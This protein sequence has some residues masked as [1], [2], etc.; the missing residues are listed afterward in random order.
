M[1]IS[2]LLQP[3]RLGPLTP[4]NRL[5]RAGTSETMATQ[6]G[7]VTDGLLR[8]YRALAAGGVGAIFTGHLFVHPRA[9]YAPRQT[10]IHHDGLL[11]GLRR[12]TDT[13]HASGGLI[14]AQL[15]HAGSQSRMP[16]VVPLTPSAVPNALTGRPVTAATDVEIA[17][18]IDAFVA[19]ARRA[20]AAGFDG[21]HIHAANG[22]LISQFLSP[23]TNQRDDQWGGD[24]ERRA[25]FLLEVVRLVRDVVPAN[26]ALAVKLGMVDGR[27]ERSGALGL[28]ET[29]PLAARLTDAG[30]DAIEVAC[31]VMDRAS[32]SAREYVAV[33]RR[34][35]AEDLL[36]HRLLATPVAEAYWLPWVRAL[37]RDVDT[38]VVAVGGMRHIQT[39]ANAIALGDAEFVAMARPFI[40]EPDL[41]AQITAGRTGRVG[42]TSCNL[43]LRH[44]G[45]HPLRCWRTPRQRLLQHAAYEVTGTL[46]RGLGK[47]A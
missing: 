3:G 28:S 7:A 42:C 24:S 29:V 40:R 16:T 19:G 30:V 11:A 1:T 8:L 12:L 38:T 33:N 34:R 14:F 4:A 47:P 39:M 15:G 32:D 10:G 22:Y 9:Q 44:E 27:A 6:D 46:A 18:A 20:V 45:H 23:L 35:A 17:G 13:V 5:V 25:H 36:V 26:R 43:C 31:G 21:V 37:R 2:P 41:V